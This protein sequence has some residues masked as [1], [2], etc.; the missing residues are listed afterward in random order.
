VAGVKAEAPAAEGEAAEAP[1]TAATVLAVRLPMAMVP[2][3]CRHPHHRHVA[4]ADPH[5]KAPGLRA[6]STL[7]LPPATT[8]TMAHGNHAMAAAS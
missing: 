5:R 6:L 2:A 7:H 3:T 8:A 4:T 1:T